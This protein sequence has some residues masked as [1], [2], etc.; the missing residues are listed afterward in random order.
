MTV[1]VLCSCK[2]FL[3][4]KHRNEGENGILHGFPVKDQIQ[5]KAAFNDGYRR[6]IERQE[7]LIQKIRVLCE[8]GSTVP[9]SA[10]ADL[11]DGKT[12]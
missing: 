12:V 9:L 1:T 7:R 8:S 6:I 10:I 3:C 4:D 5:A 2:T 11:L